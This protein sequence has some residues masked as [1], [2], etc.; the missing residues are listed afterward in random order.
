MLISVI[1]GGVF[2]GTLYNM[3]K[4]KIINKK[5]YIYLAILLVIGVLFAIY[6]NIAWFRL[7]YYSHKFEAPGALIS[8][9]YKDLGNYENPARMFNSS[10]NIKSAM[11]IFNGSGDVIEDERFLTQ[12]LLKNN[13]HPLDTYTIG[14]NSYARTWYQGRNLRVGLTEYRLLKDDKIIIPKE[15]INKTNTLVNLNYNEIQ[16]KFAGQQSYIIGMFLYTE[17]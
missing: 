1:F 15:L 14:S 12:T 10:V 2:P 13:W 17:D 8:K 5:D 7:E 3:G 11:L 4:I 16:N 6:L 9:T